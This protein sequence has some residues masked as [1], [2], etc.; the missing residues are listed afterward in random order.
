MLYINILIIT[1]SH[2]IEH[3][4]HDFFF[5]K[6]EQHFLNEMRFA[7]CFKIYQQEKYGQNFSFGTSDMSGNNN[8]MNDKSGGK[9]SSLKRLC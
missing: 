7:E 6:C 8:E 9:R 1:Y 5:V 3:I 2:H 4:L